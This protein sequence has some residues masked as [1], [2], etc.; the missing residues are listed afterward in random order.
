[1]QLVIEHFADG[2]FFMIPILVCAVFGA[3]IVLERAIY[4]FLRAALDAKSFVQQIQKHLLEGD[5]EGAIRLCNSEP[6]ALL[7]RVLKAALLRADR[8]EGELRDAVEELVLEVSPLVMRR[9]GYLPLIANVATLL[10]LLG[11]IDGLILA[12]DAVSGSTL[13]GRSQALAGGIAV[14]MYTTFFGLLVAIP[15]MVGHGLIA[16]RANAVLDD[17]DHAS[18]KV[19]NLLLASR[20]P[21]RSHGGGAPVIPFRS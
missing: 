20:R 9:V 15:V 19:I 11:T 21:E 16:A 7:P 3:T 4:V 5:T 14:A 6:S 17:I 1:M 10:G 12:F 2:G 8:P 13:E 18:A